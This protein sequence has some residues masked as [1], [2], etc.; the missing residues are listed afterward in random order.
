MSI[1]VNC[2][3]CGQRYGVRDEF[4]GRNFKCKGCG[5]VVAVPK[6]QAK[7]DD[8]E[9]MLAPL[10]DDE[11]DN[12]T[13]AVPR[14]PQSTPV[15]EGEGVTCRNCGASLPLNAVLCVSC[16]FNLKTGRH[17]E[18]VIEGT[19]DQF[20]FEPYPALRP[21][22]IVNGVL[23][24]LAVVVLL[25]IALA[26][27]TRLSVV[28]LLLLFFL[29][30]SI[31]SFAF[32]FRTRKRI[33]VSR[34]AGAGT[35]VT[36]TQFWGFW[37]RRRNLDISEYDSICFVQDPK[38]SGMVAETVVLLIIFLLMLFTC[39]LN[40]FV[41]V[42]FAILFKEVSDIHYRAEVR[43]RGTRPLVIHRGMSE[44]KY[45][46]ETVV[47]MIHA[48]TGLRKEQ[49]LGLVESGSFTL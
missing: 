37:T 15:Q 26:G 41:L 31:C 2:D 5:A 32:A 21:F 19:S 3:G 34:Q 38:G 42:R 49:E 14:R 9:Y 17:L 45:D 8:D 46:V 35:T 7:Q 36:I 25:L 30:L 28:L 11:P 16:G 43:R 27:D 40:V 4:A 20:E 13:Q 44:S 23:G 12:A 24:L 39:I 6:L 48:V 33:A 22:L 10:D 47:E 29:A 1:S 18:T